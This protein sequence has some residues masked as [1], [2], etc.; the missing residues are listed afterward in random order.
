ME[1]WNSIG[2]SSSLSSNKGL[3]ISEL[4]RCGRYRWISEPER[5]LML[6]VLEDAVRCY[7]THRDEDKSPRNRLLFADAREWINSSTRYSIFAFQNL[8]EIIG[9][10]PDRLRRERHRYRR[11]SNSRPM[12]LPRAFDVRG[13]VVSSSSQA[14]RPQR[15]R[16]MRHVA[17]G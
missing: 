2:D 10:D 4:E 12:S 14:S 17:V 8:C 16:R 6:A 9:I 11:K 15:S 13:S 3:G 7:L 5:N 1:A